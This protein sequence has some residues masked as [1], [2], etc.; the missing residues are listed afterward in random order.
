MRLTPEVVLRA[1]QRLNCC[2]QRELVLRGL[3]AP[4]VESLGVMRDGF[5]LLDLSQNAL[6]SIGAGFPP[7]PRL[8]ALYAGSNAIRRVETGLADSLP[9]LQTLVLTANAIETV[10]DLNLDELGQ[11][12]KL[13]TIAINENP[14]A[15]THGIRSLLLHRIPSLRYID[16]VRVTRAEKQ[17]A[18]SEYGPANTGE[19]SPR[20]KAGKARKKMISPTLSSVDAA[21]TVQNPKG[22]DDN[23][24]AFGKVDHQRLSAEQVH[25]I[26]A[27]ITAATSLDQVTALQRVLRS[28]DLSAIA[29]ILPK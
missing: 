28:G 21:A 7:S 25:K 24:V 13:E 12:R 17:L 23:H 10:A 1:P 22:S 16:F 3:A 27:A 15:S 26:K 11:L 9:N 6:A 8:T 5:D 29:D 18:V 14:V 19:Q 4:F 2:G 20:R